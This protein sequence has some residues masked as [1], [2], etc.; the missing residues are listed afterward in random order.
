MHL[1][2]F[3]VFALL[4]VAHC[5]LPCSSPLRFLPQYANLFAHC[6]CTYGSFS[7]W[8]KV[9][10]ID[11]PISQCSSGKVITEE[12]EQ[13]V[14]FG[15]CDPRKETRTIC[16]DYSYIMRNCSTLINTGEPE[17]VDQIIMALGLG[18]RGQMV[19]PS[20]SN[21]FQPVSNIA[22]ANR[23]LSVGGSPG[24]PGTLAITPQ[25]DDTRKVCQHVTVAPKYGKW[26]S[27]N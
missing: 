20:V 14:L 3:S 23:I 7:E 27:Y 1:L 10:T 4:A 13:R 17:L 5:Q 25:C 18:S 8:T 19:T 12:R 2:V 11:V 22:P 9:R 24:I 6:S 16:K 21:F 15:T 26:Q